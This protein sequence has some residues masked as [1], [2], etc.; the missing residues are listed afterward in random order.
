MFRDVPVASKI[1]KGYWK[2]PVTGLRPLTPEMK[3]IIYEADKTKNGGS[4]RWK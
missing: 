2:I 1:L 4:K 3:A